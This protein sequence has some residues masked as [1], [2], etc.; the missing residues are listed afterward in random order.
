L[1]LAIANNA[2]AAVEPE[3][4]PKDPSMCSTPMRRGEVAPYAGQLLSPVLAISLGQAAD[5]CDEQIALE[6]THTSSLAAVV[7]DFTRKLHRLEVEAV[8]QERDVYRAL[9]AS[10][11]EG[12][13]WYGHAMFVAAASV[14]ATLGAVYIA[15]RFSRAEGQ[16]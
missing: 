1:A 16:R 12:Q 13:A 5:H 6:V 10:E 8:T 15:T 4:D 2:V 7:L 3:C 14:L 11:A 9:Y